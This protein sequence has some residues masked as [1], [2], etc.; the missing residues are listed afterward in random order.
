VIGI[1]SRIPSLILGL[2]LAGC[3][4][5]RVV[6]Q[7][8]EVDRLL[9]S[10][11]A[12]S[13]PEEERREATFRNDLG[14]LLEREGDLEGALEQYRRAREKD[15]S[16]VLAYIN[17]GNVR[18]KLKELGEAKRLYREALERDPANPRALNNLAWVMVMENR[19]L[20]GAVA[21]LT[22]ALA[23]DPEHP[24][25]YLD[26]MGWAL[27]RKGEVDAARQTLRLAL[28]QT[29]EEEI[30][31]RAEAHYHLAVILKETGEAEEA[32]FQLR[33]SLRYHP[34]PERERELEKL[35]DGD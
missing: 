4:S 20:D 6:V 29:P 10:R 13:D 21:L 1:D 30:Y 26:T 5:Y 31:L 2:A 9:E 16:L 11:T 8:V 3:S 17:A 12:C 28:D 22:L 14:V 27:Y 23:A 25:L 33:E 19:D 35:K 34:D 24:Y 15:P 7:G 18:V 32:A